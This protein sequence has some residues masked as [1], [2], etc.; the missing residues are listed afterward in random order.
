[1]LFGRLSLYVP[2]GRE[3][4]MNAQ[5]G[6]FKQ[7]PKVLSGM[8]SVNSLDLQDQNEMLGRVNIGWTIGEETLF[9]FNK[10]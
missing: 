2:G 3:S 9:N 6:N 4:L 7:S 5:N 1:V 8:G 10:N